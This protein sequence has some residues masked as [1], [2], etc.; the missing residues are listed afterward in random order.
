MC[1]EQKQDSRYTIKQLEQMMSESEIQ[2]HGIGKVLDTLKSLDNV[3][4]NMI[5]TLFYHKL[6]E[7]EDYERESQSLAK[8]FKRH[9]KTVTNDVNYMPKKK[10]FR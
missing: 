3:D 10:R 9:H 5:E 1:K 7:I 8:A 6:H 2:R 4:G